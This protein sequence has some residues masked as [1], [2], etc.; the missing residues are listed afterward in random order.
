MINSIY[1]YTNN[2][3]KPTTSHTLH[4]NILPDH[5]ITIFTKQNKKTT[6]KTH[7]YFK[8][9]TPSNPSFTLIKNKKITKIIK[10]HQ[11]KNHNI[12]NIINQL[13]TLFNKYYKKK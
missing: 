11:I 5:L 8:N 3:T 10:K 2:I 12:I 6:Q 7:K 1:N 13:Q 9:Y 4:Y